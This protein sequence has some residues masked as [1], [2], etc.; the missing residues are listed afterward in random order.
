MKYIDSVLIDSTIEVKTKNTKS[1]LT[2]L[3]K[4]TDLST[5]SSHYVITDFTIIGI[6]E[7]LSPRGN[8]K[9]IFIDDKKEKMMIY[10]LGMPSERPKAI[11]DNQLIFTHDKSEVRIS[12]S[13]G[14][15]LFLCVSTIDCYE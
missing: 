13:G 10:S 14:L 5:H 7:M 3:G 6:N 4:I 1:T 11:L 9:L 15:P 2:Y 12:F 8:T